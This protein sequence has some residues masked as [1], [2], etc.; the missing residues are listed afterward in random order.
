[1]R[2]PENKGDLTMIS[3]LLSKESAGESG[4]WKIRSSFGVIAVLLVIGLF[5]LA[6]PAA[7]ADTWNFTLT[8]PGNTT[9][10]TF[11]FAVGAPSTAFPGSYFQLNSPVDWTL[12]G[13][14]QGFTNASFWNLSV[15]GG[16]CLGDC[17]TIELWGPQLYTGSESSPSFVEGTYSFTNCCGTPYDGPFTLTLVDPP[18][19]PT[20]TPEPSSVALLMTGLMGLIGLAVYRTWQGRQTFRQGVA[21]A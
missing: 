4:M 8:N 17:G 11:S 16:L 3:R 12:N 15:G 20:N 13:V 10:I 18:E 14:D 9:N 5:S 7:Q 19:V 6:A 2:D 1:M 21:A